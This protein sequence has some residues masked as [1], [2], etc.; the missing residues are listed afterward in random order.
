M[1]EQKKEYMMMKDLNTVQKQL[2]EAPRRIAH[3]TKGEREKI[4]VQT[5]KN[6]KVREEAAARCERVIE[7]ESAE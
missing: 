3:S 5:P 4:I 6:V 1:E 7:G 2:E